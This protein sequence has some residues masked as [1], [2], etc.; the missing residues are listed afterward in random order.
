MSSSQSPRMMPLILLSVV[1]CVIATSNA[2]RSFK[3]V[4]EGII[5]EPRKLAVVVVCASVVVIAI[6]MWLVHIIAGCVRKRRFR[7]TGGQPTSPQLLSND[8]SVSELG[9]SE[10]A[11]KV[12]SLTP[13]TSNPPSRASLKSPINDAVNTF[14]TGI[15]AHLPSPKS[16]RRT[17]HSQT[18]AHERRRR[19]PQGQD[20]GWRAVSHSPSSHRSSKGG[21][22]EASEHYGSLVANE[23]NPS[24]GGPRYARQGSRRHACPSVSWVSQGCPEGHDK[25]HSNS[26]HRG[27]QHGTP[28]R[29]METVVLTHTITYPSKYAQSPSKQIPQEHIAGS[30]IMHRQGA[31]S[32]NP[33]DTEQQRYTNRVDLPSH[34]DASPMVLVNDRPPP[35]SARSKA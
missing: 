13:S 15:P 30:S 29:D 25:H 9:T 11:T 3:S 6:L 19:H 34:H 10:R 1:P 5:T 22:F 18:P 17:S 4:I 21:Q 23:Q 12:P 24:S 16:S 20:H 26:S 27:Q 14:N 8:I 7:K 28:L 33:S 35:Y 31:V 32:Q 2:S